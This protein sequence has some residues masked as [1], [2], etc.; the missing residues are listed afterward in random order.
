MVR[1]RIMITKAKA[2]QIIARS[3]HGLFAGDVV[4]DRGR[5][6]ACTA[7]EGFG[8]TEV[9]GIDEDGGVDIVVV[10]DRWVDSEGCDVSDV[11]YWEFE[12]ISTSCRDSECS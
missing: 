3:S 2:T 7:G 8:R 10:V 4:V 6:L 12:E 1:R 5:V 9:D 11:L